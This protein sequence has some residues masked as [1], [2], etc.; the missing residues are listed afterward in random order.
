MFLLR[1]LSVFFRFRCIASYWGRQCGLKA[2]HCSSYLP[3]ALLLHKYF[4]DLKVTLKNAHVIIKKKIACCYSKVVTLRS[5][6]IHTIILSKDHSLNA[7]TFLKKLV[8]VSN[9][10]L[11]SLQLFVCVFFFFATL[12]TATF[13]HVFHES[14]NLTETFSGA[15][16]ADHATANKLRRGDS[17]SVCFLGERG[18]ILSGSSLCERR[19][20]KGPL[21]A[22]PLTE[23]RKR[24]PQV[25]ST[26]NCHALQSTLS[27]RLQ[28]SFP[29]I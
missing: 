18:V 2:N 4:E 15:W 13:Q 22:L 7:E 26:E 8:H 17:Q 29:Q 19:P 1:I 16:L 5:F 21:P 6:R 20:S 3:C 27:I 10:D 23:M 12:G 11:K 24:P 25:L 14:N 28:L 9:N